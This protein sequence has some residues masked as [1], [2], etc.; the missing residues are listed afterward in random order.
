MSCHPAAGRH[1]EANAA[2][3]RLVRALQPHV[4]PSSSRPPLKGSRARVFL[5]AGLPGQQGSRAGSRARGCG[6]ISAHARGLS[7]HR[8]PPETMRGDPNTPSTF[9]REHAAVH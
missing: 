9:V 2:V 7:P 3:S 4:E 6:Q 8:A 1:G 5:V